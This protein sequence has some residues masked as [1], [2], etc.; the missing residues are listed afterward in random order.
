MNDSLK[1]QVKERL[2]ADWVI[3]AFSMNSEEAKLLFEKENEDL[4]A[5]WLA[6]KQ[7]IEQK[8]YRSSCEYGKHPKGIY[9]G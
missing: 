7:R 5:I 8:R 9:G 6:T 1:K 2:G 4:Y 3:P